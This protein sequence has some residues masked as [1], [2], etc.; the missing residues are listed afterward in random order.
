MIIPVKDMAGKQVG[1]LE[2]SEGVFAAPVNKPLMHQALVRQLANARL[3]THKTKGRSEVRGG[4]RKPWRQKG[5]G[6]ARQGSTRAP[7]WVGGGTVFGPQ[8]RKYTKALPKKMNQAALR[9]ALSVKVDAG[10]IVVLDKLQMD[11]PKTKTMVDAL[12]ALGVVDSSVLMVLPEKNAAVQRS[13]NN[14]SNVKTLLAG[15]LNIR[16][17]LGYDTVL[18]DKAAI[19]HIEGWLA[20]GGADKSDAA[21]AEGD[22]E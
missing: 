1:E 19:D 17:L 7:N 2:L 13:A 4:G 21:Q 5:T 3:G 12:S 8:P 15:Y 9:S 16:D 10:Q 6:R 20:P 14:L 22:E 18:L 11:A